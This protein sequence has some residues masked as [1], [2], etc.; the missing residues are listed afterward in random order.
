MF[1]KGE[2]WNLIKKK[3]KKKNKRK[4][5]EAKEVQEHVLCYKGKIILWEYGRAV[6]ALR[7]P[8]AA[9]NPCNSATHPTSLCSHRSSNP[10]AKLQGECIYFSVT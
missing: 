5:K 2:T 6:V 3:R 1:L 8:K 7:V 9:V 10:P 4:E